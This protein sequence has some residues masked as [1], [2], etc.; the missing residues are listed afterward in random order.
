MI[1]D[2]LIGNS[3][4]NQTSTATRPGALSDP[5]GRPRRP[6]GV[7]VRY[8]AGVGFV[9][10]DSCRRLPCGRL[11]DFDDRLRFLSVGRVRRRFG[12]RVTKEFYARERMSLV[13]PRLIRV[14]RRAMSDYGTF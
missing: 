10:V 13:F 5:R 1:C 7:P 6:D 12:E 4:A 8:S 11:A 3:R 2:G 14:A 9:E